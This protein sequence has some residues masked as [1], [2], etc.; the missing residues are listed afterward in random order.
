MI[1]RLTEATTAELVRIGGKASGLVRLMAA[2]FDVPETWVI[3]ADV[4]IDVTRRQECLD[5]QLGRW[6]TQVAAAYP[7]SRWAVR[8]SAVAEDLEG[9]SFAG[10]YETVLGVDSADTLVCAV[11]QCW[12]SVACDRATRYLDTQGMD[13]S[14]GIALLLQ[15]MVEADVAGVMLTENPLCP[16]DE[17][18]VIEACWGLGEAVVSGHT[19]P[20]HIVLHRVT[21]EVVR[22]RIGAKQVETVWADGLVERAVPDTRRQICCLAAK[23]LAALH[24]V[25]IRAESA[26]GPRRDLEWAIERNRLYVLQDR[27]ITGLPPREPREVWTR[28]FGDEY[29]ADYTTPL[30]YDLTI[31]WLTG[32]Q[33]DE[34]AVLQGRPEIV[35]LDKFRRH[36]G[37]VYFNGG[38]ALEFFRC[39]PA[40]SRRGSA[41]STWFDPLFFARLM[42]VPFE[43]RLLLRTL[44][45]PRKDKRRGGMRDNLAAL[46]HHAAA[47]DERLV[48]KLRQDYAALTDSQWRAQFTEADRFGR[49]HFRVIRW[50]M[51]QHGPAL[52]ILLGK[53]LAAWVGEDAA[54]ALQ[55]L[56]SGLP[57][58]F[59]AAINRDV[60]ELG[61]LARQDRN[62]LA[63]LRDNLPYPEVRQASATSA[64][65]PPFDAFLAAHGHRSATREISAERWHE[66]P[67]IVLGLVRAQVRPD[68]P[69]TSPADSEAAAQRRREDEE[70]RIRGALGTGPLAVVRRAV[71][72]RVL[73]RLQAY[74]L[75]RENQRYYLDYILDHLRRLLLEQGRR[76]TEQGF[77]ADSSDVFLL[78]GETFWQ[79]V[80]RP[81]EADRKSVA[82][83]VAAA[84][85]HRE[86]NASNLPAAYLFDG[87]PTEG[88]TA[89]PGGD[90]EGV[91]VGFGASA[92]QA[93]GIA[94]PVTAFADLASV[95]H[96]DILVASNIDPGWTS[97]FPLIAGLVTE[98]GG[99]LSH[100]AILAREYGIP[101]VTSLDGALGLLP[102]GGRVRVDGSTGTVMLLA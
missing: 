70:R 98:T 17:D 61:L 84:R 2:G 38:L 31:P 85:E 28:R 55:T 90:T 76:L 46:E 43:P 4:S 20:D 40:E 42:A 88:K 14:T 48:P 36:D 53:L 71:L 19:E 73:G 81:G 35:A 69:G 60:W 41:L 95:E 7:D 52:Q 12:R 86:R 63:A 96:G 82:A 15:R 87:V 49:D 54:D 72:G 23:H 97:V 3:P 24:T 100:G 29:L 11:E 65:W 62:L 59:T 101:T 32:P 13:S 21:G 58:T 80:D 64:F 10:V 78:T 77:L 51:G 99:V 34:V 18:V 30:G 8:S 33:I 94:R 79:L 45:T 6:W 47:L 26:I 91:L 92:G 5:A 67:D 9:A 56:I 1:E 89:A 44:T 75:Y 37:Y 83:E 25:A 68:Q 22:T 50:G 93:E 57:G 102:A 66:Q 74:T 39:L 27:P 16:F